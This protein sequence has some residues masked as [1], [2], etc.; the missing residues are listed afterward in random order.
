MAHKITFSL[1]GRSEISES[2]L[3]SLPDYGVTVVGISGDIEDINV[4][5]RSSLAVLMFLVNNAGIETS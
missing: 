1:N 5:W 2:Y 3:H 4:W